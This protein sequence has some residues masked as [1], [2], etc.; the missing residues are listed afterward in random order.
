MFSPRFLPPLR[1]RHLFRRVARGC[2]GRFHPGFAPAGGSSGLL[3]H[4]T[5]PTAPPRG[6]AARGSPARARAA[7]QF[8]STGLRIASPPTGFPR[9]P[10]LR[11]SGSSFGGV[12]GLAPRSLVGFGSLGRLRGLRQPASSLPP[13]RSCLGG[14]ARRGQLP[15]PCWAK[16]LQELIGRKPLSG[17]KPAYSGSSPAAS[18][19]LRLAHR[20]SPYKGE[21]PCEGGGVR[22][23]RGKKVGWGWG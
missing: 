17:A 4:R 2:G 5:G 19:A 12:G 22:R 7:G 1:P 21:P 15:H 14:H 9:Q 10:A 6:V 13:P 8:I 3:R 11:A 20:L 23:G 18:H 16:P